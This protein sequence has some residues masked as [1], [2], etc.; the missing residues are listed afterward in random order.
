MAGCSLPGLV[1]RTEIADLSTFD[2]WADCGLNPVTRG[3]GSNVKLP[4]YLAMGLAVVT[5]SFGLRGYTPLAKA[6]LSVP[7]ED[8]AEALHARPRGWAARGEAPPAALA[9]YAWGALGAGLADSLAARRAS[10]SAGK[11]GAA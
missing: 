6:V 2:R 4:G 5:T 3:G 7:L 8:T 11:A 10:S 9:G 1:A